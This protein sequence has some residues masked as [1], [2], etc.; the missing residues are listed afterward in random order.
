MSWRRRSLPRWVSRRST[1][2]ETRP[3]GQVATRKAKEVAERCRTNLRTTHGLLDREVPADT[4]LPLLLAGQGR[5]SRARP[6]ARGRDPR[7][8]PPGGVRLVLP[9]AGRE[10]SRHVRGQGR[11]L[12]GPEDGVV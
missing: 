5:G 7:G 11:V 4:D 1:N 9:A 10:A 8:Q 6:H 2:R 12:R 3:N